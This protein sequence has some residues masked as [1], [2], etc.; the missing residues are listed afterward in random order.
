MSC[1]GEVPSLIEWDAD[2]SFVDPN[3]DT[4]TDAAFRWTDAAIGLIPNANSS[5]FA[6]MGNEQS[7][8]G[9]SQSTSFSF[10]SNRASVKKPGG[11]VRVSD[12]QI[13]QID[14]REDADYKRLMD[15]PRFLPIL[16]TAVPAGRQAVPNENLDRLSHRPIWRLSVRLQSHLHTQA[17]TICLQQAKITQGIKTADVA[18]ATIAAKLVE[19]KKKYDRLRASLAQV[20]QL[21]D[22]VVRIQILLEE[23]VPCVETVNELLTPANRLPPLDLK[24]IFADTGSSTGP[25]MIT[26]I[27][28]TRVVDQD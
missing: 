3:W 8:A 1:E 13:K 27:E 12:G 9:S 14:P 26:P 5:L 25:Y 15:I 18:S 11:I 19:R 6:I 4:Q 22:E 7:A 28:E 23:I 2:F 10:L 20:T 16:R 24:K 21:R 17:Q